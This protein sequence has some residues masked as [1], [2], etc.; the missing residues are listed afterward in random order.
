MS[1]DSSIEAVVA[2][3]NTLA[4]ANLTL[5]KAL[6]YYADTVNKFGLKIEKGNEGRAPVAEQEEEAPVA[7][8]KPR[9]RPKKEAEPA[10]EVEEEDDGFGDEDEGEDDAVDFEKVKGAL[11]ALR[12]AG[13]KDKALKIMNDKGYKTIPDIKEKDFK[14]IYD[15]CQKLLK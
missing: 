13:Q 9:G 1:I 11:K 5:A 10:P 15:A 12:D 6:T 14:A 3:N 8:K 4:E 7:E 2:S